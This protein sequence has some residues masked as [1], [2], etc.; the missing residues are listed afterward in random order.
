MIIK[1]RKR[2]TNDGGSQGKTF[3]YSSGKF[4]KKPLSFALE[5]KICLSSISLLF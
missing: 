5:N 3:F 4:I 1:K 2:S